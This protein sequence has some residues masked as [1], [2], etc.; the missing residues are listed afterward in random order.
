MHRSVPPMKTNQ[1]GKK[2]ANPIIF[3]E[4]YEAL[5]TWRKKISARGPTMSSKVRW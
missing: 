1:G 5:G 3:D 4:C 2:N